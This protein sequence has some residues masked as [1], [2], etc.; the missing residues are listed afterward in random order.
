MESSERPIVVNCG[1]AISLD[2]KFVTENLI[3]R[4]DYY[5]MYVTEG[6]LNVDVG[7]R[8]FVAERGD[9]IVFPPK[10][11][12]RYSHDGDDRIT[13]LWAHFSGS[14]AERCLKECGF[15]Q[16]P[17]IWRG[18]FDMRIQRRFEKLFDIYAEGGALRDARLGNCFEDILLCAAEQMRGERPDGGRFYTSLKYMSSNYSSDIKI[19]ELAQMENLS[20]SRYNYLFRRSVGISPKSYLINLR[21]NTA[22]QLLLE[23][24]MS[25]KQIAVCVGYDDGC[26]FSRIFKTH[27]SLSPE[28]FRESRE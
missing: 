24:D 3:G 17:Q 1:G 5:F 12:Y 11:S 6:K 20:V 13:Y 25:V 14:H 28:Q 10:L 8:T 4:L 16:L 21:L 27:N 19:S 15:A 18:S 26:Y 2:T 9:M 7:E 22:R 23:T